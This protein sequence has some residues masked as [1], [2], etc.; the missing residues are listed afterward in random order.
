MASFTPLIFYF[1]LHVY[2]R[3]RRKIRTT[4][5]RF[6][7]RDPSQLNYLLKTI[8]L[9]SDYKEMDPLHSIKAK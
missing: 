2:T 8:P 1:F 6:I 9:Y 3:E 4:N 5:I 7:T